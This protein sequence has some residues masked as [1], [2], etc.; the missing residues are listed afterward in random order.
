MTW[1]TPRRSRASPRCVW[2]R[3]DVA[4][5]SGPARSPRTDPTR[6]LTLNRQ[7]DKSVLM[8]T[9][10]PKTAEFATRQLHVDKGRLLDDRDRTA[11]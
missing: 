3:H 11:A 4:N 2:R 9:H 10:D 8:V 5:P 7:Y 1:L 6:V